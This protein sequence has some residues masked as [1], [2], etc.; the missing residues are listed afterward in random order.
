MNQDRLANIQQT[1]A[2]GPFAAS[3]D[4]LEQYQVP[5]WYIDGKFYIVPNGTLIGV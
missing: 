2:A 5:D 1:I 4:S 3:W